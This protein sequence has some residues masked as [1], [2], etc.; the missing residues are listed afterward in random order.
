MNARPLAR[1]WHPLYPLLGVLLLVHVAANGIRFTVL[2]DGVRHGASAVVIGL[3]GA[4]FFLMPMLMSLRLGQFIDRHGARGPM[5]ASGVLLSASALAGL[6]A[7][8]VW[9]LFATAFISGIGQNLYVVTMQRATGEYGTGTERAVS[10]SLLGLAYSIASFLAPVLAGAIIQL[11]GLQAAYAG[12]AL[13]PFAGL[14]VLNRAKVR[15]PRGH[16][17]APSAAQEKRRTV[18][19]LRE[20][21]LRR[22]YIVGALFETSWSLFA[23]LSPVYGSQLGLPAVTI[24][25]IAGSMSASTIV[26]RVVL[27]MLVRRVPM[28]R[29]LIASLVVLALGYLGFSLSA[30]P[31]LLILFGAVIGIGQSVGGPLMNAYLFEIAP[32]GRI[33]EATGLRIT[34]NSTLAMLIP[35]SSGAVTAAVG[36]APAFWALSAALLAGSWASRRQ[37]NRR[38]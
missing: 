33:G 29:L 26:M 19:L 2:L 12:G 20:P 10:Y 38:A 37:W 18:D 21:N 3:L 1:F 32:P 24:G 22:A 28:W 34:F 7:G 30:S 15:L 31:A 14:L 8:N 4:S 23:F 25:L 17:N 13:L 9:M 5:L 35:L 16:G 6:A 36:I 11:G 27:P